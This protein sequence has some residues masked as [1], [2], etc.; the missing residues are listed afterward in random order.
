MS[1]S[2][3]I[4]QKPC[5]ACA[6]GVSLAADRCHCGHV[7]ESSAQNQSPQEAALRDE[8]LYESYLAARAEQAR[9]AAH[10]A[11]EARAEKSDVDQRMSAAELAVE[12]ANA[13]ETDLATQRAKIS[14]LRRAL[15]VVQSLAPVA[16][17]PVVLT[18]VATA[19]VTAPLNPPVV[20]SILAARPA[21]PA[22]Q[23]PV[24]ANPVPAAR[25]SASPVTRSASRWSRATMGCRA[26]A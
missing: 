14:A 11:E 22:T 5:P 3:S 21:P 13:V 24:Q 10:H 17:A 26:P 23:S 2:Y 15:P 1:S 25:P 16:P 18:P 7:F 8:E 12:V 6:S 9:Q 19:P 20:T 4:F